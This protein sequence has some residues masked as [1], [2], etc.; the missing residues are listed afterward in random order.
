MNPKIL[1]SFNFKKQGYPEFFDRLKELIKFKLDDC[2]SIDE[3]GI[4]N[5]REKDLLKLCNRKKKLLD[6]LLLHEFMHFFFLHPWENADT[7]KYFDDFNDAADIY[8]DNLIFKY[9]IKDKE[10]HKLAMYR[11][12]EFL[13]EENKSVWDI[14]LIIL[15]RRG[16]DDEEIRKNLKALNLKAKIQ[17]L[18]FKTLICQNRKK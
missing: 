6:Y 13:G 15:E 9:F 7:I 4:F 14:Y 12:L 11:F 3:A 18:L 17:E 8:I 1:S 2:W 10:M 16:L 5:Y